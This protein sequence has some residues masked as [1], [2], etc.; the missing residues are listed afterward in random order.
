MEAPSILKHKAFNIEAQSFDIG[1]CLNAY[2]EEYSISKQLDIEEIAFDIEDSSISGGS[3][4]PDIGHFSFLGAS[5]SNITVFYIGIYSSISK[6]NVPDIEA[7]DLN[8]DIED[9]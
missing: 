7:Q 5:I 4:I 1:I 9:S 2:I 3:H 8:F 6:I